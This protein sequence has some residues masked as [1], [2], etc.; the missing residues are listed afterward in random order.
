M[1]SRR[2]SFAQFMGGNFKAAGLVRS[3]SS[4]VHALPLI[5]PY[6]HA[7]QW[8]SVHRDDPTYWDQRWPFRATARQSKTY[9][10]EHDEPRCRPAAK[11]RSRPPSFS[12]W[13]CCHALLAGRSENKNHTA[14]QFVAHAS[15]CIDDPQSAGTT[16]DSASQGEDRYTSVCTSI[17]SLIVT[18]APSR[19]PN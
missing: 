18:T 7:R 12:Y 9:R 16:I 2:H 10:G 1:L 19:N 11:H 15:I 3:A 17:V 14:T 13:I 6:G 5:K 8:L 4:G